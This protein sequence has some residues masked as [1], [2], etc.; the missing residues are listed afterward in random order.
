MHHYTKHSCQCVNLFFTTVYVVHEVIH[1]LYVKCLNRHCLHMA[2]YLLY[3]INVFLAKC[4]N[5]HKIVHC[6]RSLIGRASICTG[7]F[8]R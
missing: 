1:V 2:V 8:S 5:S 6:D 4:V 3:T 7:M